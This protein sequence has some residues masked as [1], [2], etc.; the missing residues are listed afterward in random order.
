MNKELEL[1]ISI[2]MEINRP[3]ACSRQSQKTFCVEAAE[4]GLVK[5]IQMRWLIVQRKGDINQYKFLVINN[6]PFVIFDRVCVIFYEEGNY[7]IKRIEENIS[8]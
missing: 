3:Y 2:P 6:V 5:G 8:T 4:S 7:Y 1:N